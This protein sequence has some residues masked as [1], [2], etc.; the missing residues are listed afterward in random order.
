MKKNLLEE[1]KKE[2]KE[3]K[4]KI[5]EIEFIGSYNGLYEMTWDEYKIHSDFIYDSGY[6]SEEVPRDL[7]IVFSDKSFLRR[8]SYDGSEWWEYI[9]IPIRRMNPKKVKN[10]RAYDFC[11]TIKSANEDLV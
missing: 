9:Q 6:G 2:L 7:V 1:T 10:L 3:I 8:Q 11:D 4:K 5:N